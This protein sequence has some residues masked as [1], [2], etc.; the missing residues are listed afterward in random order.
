[1]NG[2]FPLELSNI[3]DGY[4]DI[5]DLKKP[6]K[7][8]EKKNWSLLS[9]FNKNAFH[10]LIKNRDKIDYIN[11]A[12]NENTAVLDYLFENFDD[13]LKNKFDTSYNDLEDLFPKTMPVSMSFNRQIN[14]NDIDKFQ[15][16]SDFA[17]NLSKNKSESATIILKNYNKLINW[18]ELIQN[19]NDIAAELTLEKMKTLNERDSASFYNILISNPN[20]K[21]VDYMIKKHTEK[22][23]VFNFDSVSKN[24]NP[25]VVFLLKQI[26]DRFILQDNPNTFGRIDQNQLFKNKQFLNK[27]PKDEFVELLENHEIIRNY[28]YLSMNNSDK[29]IQILKDKPERINW[30][31]LAYNTNPEA[32]N[33]LIKYHNN[34][35]TNNKLVSLS[36]NNSEYAMQK[37]LELIK[38]Q[39]ITIDD[40][41]EYKSNLSMNEHAIKLL[42]RY[43]ELIDWN[44]IWRNPNIFEKKSIDNFINNKSSRKSSRSSRSSRSRSRK[45][46]GSRKSSNNSRGNNSRGNNSRGSE[47]KPPSKSVGGKKYLLINK[48]RKNKN[49]ILSNKKRKT[50]KN[51]NNIL[52]NKK[53]KT[54]KNKN[55]ILSNKKRKTRKSKSN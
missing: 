42:T 19:P 4:T 31:T 32:I 24:T 41:Q 47:T 27:N 30:N 8:Y 29:A 17:T 9:S 44:V 54:R 14:N 20:D 50:R 45:S 21:I 1:M 51:K 33:M 37:L 52:S 7:D 38:K 23:I 5:Y 2:H 12:L 10:L 3:I 28:F 11:L 25:K 39:L 13:I 22:F 46:S 48:T 18:N 26:I 36:L 40:L 16:L 53:R 49:N 15:K 43:P 55:N 35:N 34:N 6:F